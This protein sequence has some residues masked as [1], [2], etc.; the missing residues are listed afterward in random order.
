MCMLCSLKSGILI[1]GATLAVRKKK[2]SEN[3]L[4]FSLLSL[5]AVPEQLVL[6]DTCLLGRL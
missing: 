1:L 4:E 5:K 2:N 6:F 3:C